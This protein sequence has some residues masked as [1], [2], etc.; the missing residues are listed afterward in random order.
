MTWFVNIFKV[1]YNELR[2]IIR[3]EGIMIFIILVPLA[4]P[5]LYAF[6]YTTETQH[7]LPVCVVD[8]CNSTRSRE[9]IRKVD[10][11]PEVR[12]AG[13]AMN[14]AEAQELLRKREVSGIIEIPRSFDRDLAHGKQVVV[15]VFSDLTSML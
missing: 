15:G 2:D 4:Y 11:T 6:I 10:S 5:L 8:Q 14:M 9:F 12:I 3:D 1:W 7:N 13:N